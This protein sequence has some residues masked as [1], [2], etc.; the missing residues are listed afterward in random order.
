RTRAA[1]AV[2]LEPRRGASARL[3]DGRRAGREHEAAARARG[4]R[5]RRRAPGGGSGGGPQRRRHA[6]RGRARPRVRENDRPACHGAARAAGGSGAFGRP[7]THRRAGEAPAVR[8]G[9]LE[10]AERV[11]PD[12]EERSSRAAARSGGGVRGRA[13]MGRAFPDAGRGTGRESRGSRFES[14]LTSLKPQD[15]G[16]QRLC[17]TSRG[18]TPVLEKAFRVSGVPEKLLSLFALSHDLRWTWRADVRSLFEDLDAEAWERVRG[19]PV[20]LLRELSAERLRNAAD[21]PAFQEKLAAVVGRPSHEDQGEP[22]HSGARE[23][24]RRGGGV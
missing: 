3:S 19:N 13:R 22:R 21:D 7:R 23:L 4:S 2:S 20:R 15:L 6:A 12:G 24:V 9:F 1:D 17:Y 5:A 14:R 11:L 16:L 8:S 18:L 10:G